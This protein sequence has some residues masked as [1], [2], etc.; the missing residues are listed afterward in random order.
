MQGARRR[1]HRR[2]ATNRITRT[3]LTKLMCTPRPRCLP[4]HSR[5]M[6]VPYDT[7][8]HW[9]FLV[10]QSTHTCGGRTRRRR[11]HTRS[12]AG[13]RAV[14]QR[15]LRAASVSALAG[16][17]AAL[18]LFSGLDC[19]SRRT[20]RAWLD[21]LLAAAGCGVKRRWRLVELLAVFAAPHE[22]QRPEPGASRLSRLI[23]WRAPAIRS[24]R[25]SRRPLARR[26]QTISSNPPR[27]HGAVVCGCRS[28]Q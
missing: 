10:S 20:R 23:R 2:A 16:R 19:S 7:V 14:G 12:A 21:M 3:H 9:G 28:S 4:L 1:A 22:L 13:M 26:R 6:K 18:A 24:C 15:T 5:H 27:P 8:A 25:P 17:P 11:Q